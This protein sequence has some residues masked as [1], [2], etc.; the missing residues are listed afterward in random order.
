MAECIACGREAGPNKIY[1]NEVCHDNA[2]G[3]N[4][5]DFR[6]QLMDAYTRGRHDGAR[7]EREKT[8]GAL[9]PRNVGGH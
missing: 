1:C 9:W 7:E 8:V 5:R 6:R 2:T 3:Q 4:G